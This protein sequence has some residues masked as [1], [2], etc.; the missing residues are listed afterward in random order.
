MV[1][2]IV[3]LVNGTSDLSIDIA[4]TIYYGLF[5]NDE[6][7]GETEHTFTSPSKTSNIGITRILEVN[8]GDYFNVYTKSLNAAAN[9][10][11]KSLSLTFWGNKNK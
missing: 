10:E 8:P 9:I 7:V 5:I 6:L 2:S 3:C 1:E 4:T 11:I